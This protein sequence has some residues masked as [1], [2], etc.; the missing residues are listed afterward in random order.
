MPST[1]NLVREVKALRVSER[2]MRGPLEALDL[3]DIAY[4]AFEHRVATEKE[5]AN[6]LPWMRCGRRG[7]RAGAG[8]GELTCNGKIVI[9]IKD[10]TGETTH[11]KVK[12]TTPMSKVFKADARQKG[13]NGSSL[14]F[15]LDGDRIQSNATPE[16][17]KLESHDQIDCLLE[18]TGD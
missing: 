6:V 15:L 11:Y 16:E 14:R 13:V 10:Q 7:N 1:R 3:R 2:C 8:F 12:G 9:S 17:L 4:L 5:L 18:Q